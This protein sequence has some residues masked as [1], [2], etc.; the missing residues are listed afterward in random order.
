MSSVLINGIAAEYVSVFDRGLHYGDGLFETIACTGGRPQFVE[1]HLERMARGARVLDIPCPDRSL[2][3]DDIRRL[4]EDS[5]RNSVIKL[6]LIRGQGKRGYRYDRRSLPTRVC[7]LAAWP[8][9]VDRWQRHGVSTQFCATKVSGNPGAH[10]IKSLNRLENVLASGELRDA[11]DEGF[12]S[13]ADGNV[14]EGTMSNFFAVSGDALVTPDL[15]RGGIQGIMRD[16][17]IDIAR[18]A[19]IELETRHINRDELL[20]ARELF[21]CNSVIGLCPV[22]RLEQ[23]GFNTGEMTTIIR[24]ALLRRMRA[25]AEALD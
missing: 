2:F 16:R 10:G 14:I 21:I 23:V 3:L 20:G 9:Y 19:G 8:E 11:I 6:M 4:L 5:R 18:E 1:H 15:S 17:I 12:L 25:D 13:D 24:T 22:R 7:M